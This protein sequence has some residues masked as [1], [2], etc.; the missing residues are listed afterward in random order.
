MMRLQEILD[1]PAA[2]THAEKLYLALAAARARPGSDLAVAGAYRGGAAAILAGSC[3]DCRVRVIDLFDNL[4]PAVADRSLLDIH[5]G[6]VDD[7][8]VANPGLSLDFLFVDGDHSLFGALRHARHLL[9][10]A[11]KG[12]EAAFNECRAGQNGVHACCDALQR[13][14]VLEAVGRVDSILACRVE[15]G[16]KWPEPEEYGAIL[17]KEA[18]DQWSSLPEVLSP[19][20]ILA[21]D[22]L[23]EGGEGVT[24]VGRGSFGRF[25]AMVAGHPLERLVDSPEVGPQTECCIICSHK[26]REIRS[27]LIQEAGVRPDAV[28]SGL[29]VL[30]AALFLDLADN[31]G[32]G[33]ASTC[34]DEFEVRVLQSCLSIKRALLERLAKS[35]AL[36][37]LFRRT[38]C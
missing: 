16:A 19:R 2:L 32:R 24:I 6:P 35:L 8:A 33:L 30:S 25:L 9:P 17:R 37:R 34:R 28:H 36:V 11:A 21:A 1:A 38:D 12:G 13:S 26:E 7:F 27:Y 4:D 20:A 10:L 23:R 29:E 22:H 14:G 3:T 31:Q 18:E 15:P 5:I